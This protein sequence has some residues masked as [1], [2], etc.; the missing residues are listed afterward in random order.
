MAAK[1]RSKTVLDGGNNFLKQQFF[2][3]LSNVDKLASMKKAPSY[4]ITKNKRQPLSISFSPGPAAYS[5]T[6]RTKDG[7]TIP[8]SHRSIDKLNESNTASFSNPPVEKG[9][10]YTIPKSN[11]N[12]K[13]YVP[14]S[15]G[16]ADYSPK[17]A[18]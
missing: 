7:I 13:K 18:K 3:L 12:E 9:P 16:P 4:S 11:S 17:Q 10:S 1:E 5:P 2:N 15:P 14:R 8:K 6:S